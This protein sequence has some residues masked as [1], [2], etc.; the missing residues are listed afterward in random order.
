MR[1]LTE[2]NLNETGTIVA[3]KDECS[4]RQRLN[5]IGLV[6]GSDIECVLDSAKHNPK[7]F[8]IKNAVFALRSSLS[9]YVLIE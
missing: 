5:D 4:L 6:Q 9:Q 7:A 2:L 1:T 3:I 8:R